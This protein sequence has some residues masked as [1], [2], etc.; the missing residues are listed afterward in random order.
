MFIAYK[1]IEWHCTSMP[2]TR[3]IMTRQTGAL[4]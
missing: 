1:F 4:P 2:Q 3:R